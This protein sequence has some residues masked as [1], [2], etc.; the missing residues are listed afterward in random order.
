MIEEAAHP[1]RAP[2][3]TGVEGRAATALT[4]VIA[5]PTA[6]GKSA[7]ALAIAE[8][9]GG[10]IINA[11]AIQLYREF[12]VLSA[13][14]DAAACLRAPHHLYG[15]LSAREP[16]SAGR[17]R[18][19]AL[20][21]IA[22]ARRAGKLPI[23]VGGSGLY[24]RALT[25]GLAPVPP[26][27]PA[28]RAAAGALLAQ[29]G[30]SKFRRELDPESAARIRPGDT[31]RLL[32][33]WEVLS[34]TGR[35]LA[36]WQ[37]EPAP[38]GKERFATILLMPERAALYAACDQRFD[39]MVAHGALDEARALRDDPPPAIAKAVGVRPLLRHLRGEIGLERA[40]DEGKRE[41]RHYAKRQ[42]TWFRNQLRAEQTHSTQYSESLKP[43][44][45]SFI[46]DFQ[47]TADSQASIRGSA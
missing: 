21:A 41:T 36:D 12:R 32:R 27:P 24:L 14:P 13:R 38:S 6:S 11:D 43:Q 20:D 17:Y 44:I 31:Q 5:G 7:A 2:K 35:S 46:S 3:A 4:V 28:V 9:L 8:A 25:E 10:A 40:I 23:V 34:A 26:V 15:V 22:A 45:L 1:G 47:L 39:R 29:L 37:R 18:A 16:C 30:E 42:I 19:L 33:A